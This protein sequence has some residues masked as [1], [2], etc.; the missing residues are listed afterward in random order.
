MLATARS[1]R[2][3]FWKRIRPVFA[4]MM[5]ALS[6]RTTGSLVDGG[7]ACGI[8]GATTTAVGVA[9]WMPGAGLVV[10]Q[11]TRNKAKSEGENLPNGHGL[12][13]A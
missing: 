3:F 6:A 4:S 10:L 13:I 5:M 12:K 1:V 7:S 2:A 11:E 9:F 8:C